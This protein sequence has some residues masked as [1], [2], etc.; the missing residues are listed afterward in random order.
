MSKYFAYIESVIRQHLEKHPS[1]P[2]EQV[3]LVRLLLHV[4]NN[5]LDSRNRL[6]K[7]VK[8]NHTLFEAMIVIYSQPD[9]QI[10]PSKLSDILASSRTNAT[11]ISDELVNHGWVERHAVAEDRRCFML[12]MSAKGIEFLESIF[13]RQWELMESI[14]GVLDQKEMKDLY[15][16]LLKISTRLEETQ[17][18]Y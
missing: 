5:Y 4:S 12:K 13:P 1:I 15:S 11:R 10:Q 2:A 18:K 8:L 6:L 16:L 3:L 9:H 14:F 7:E 17:A